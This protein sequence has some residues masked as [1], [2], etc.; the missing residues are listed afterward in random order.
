MPE[1]TFA[2]LRVISVWQLRRQ[3]SVLQVCAQNS[4]YH[5]NLVWKS[6]SY[7]GTTLHYR[8]PRREKV[9]EINSNSARR[10]G[11]IENGKGAAWKEERKKEEEAKM[12]IDRGKVIAFNFFL[13][14]TYFRKD[15]YVWLQ[16]VWCYGMSIL[17]RPDISSTA[18]E[19]LIPWNANHTSNMVQK[20]T[21]PVL[22][23]K[24][25]IRAGRVTW[26]ESSHCV[27]EIIFVVG[28]T[29]L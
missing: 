3:S 7:T 1:S 6:Q 26:I 19:T 18:S 24:S 11:E 10:G 9:R 12:G 8:D 17:H 5:L 15:L 22:L 16:H 14:D 27:Q 20:L 23:R 25:L 29:F 4:K 2:K 13:L 21:L 28:T